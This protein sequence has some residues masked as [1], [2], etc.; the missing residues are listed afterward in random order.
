M[1]TFLADDVVEGKGVFYGSEIQVKA[2]QAGDTL[3]SRETL[4]QKDVLARRGVS[5]AISR[6]CCV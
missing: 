4:E 3:A 5:I 6:S 2:E 1:V